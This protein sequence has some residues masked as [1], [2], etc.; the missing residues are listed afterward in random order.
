VAAHLRAYR[1]A[2]FRVEV[3]VLA[4]PAAMSNQGIISR[5]LEQVADQ[6][7]G[8][9]SVQAK[10]DQAYAGVLDFA[11]LICSEHLADYVGVFR[12]GESDPR[13]R[14]VLSAEGAWTT[15]PRL[16]AAIERERPWTAHETAD[17]LAT[18]GLVR[19]WD[20]ADPSH[21]RQL[22]Q[23]LTRLSSAVFQVTAWAR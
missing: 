7:H 13:Y 11:E 1:Q 8:R 2:G 14:N 17:F 21:L 5:Y 12:R 19:L 22:G 16:R 9:L 15:E 23:P 6:G 20:I 3:M 18:H 4:V 10:A